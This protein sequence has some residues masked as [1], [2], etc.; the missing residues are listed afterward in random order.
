MVL[1]PRQRLAGP[2]AHRG[3]L[4]VARGFLEEL[5]GVLVRLD[6]EVAGVALVELVVVAGV[7]GGLHEG[8]VGAGGGACG[9]PRRP[10]TSS[11]RKS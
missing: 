1:Q 9:S 8:F 11:G 7:G 4:G 5:D 6:A 10:W 3:V 2:G